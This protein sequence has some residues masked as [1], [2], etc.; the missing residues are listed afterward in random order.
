[1]N[2]KMFKSNHPKPYQRLVE[3]NTVPN[4]FHFTNMPKEHVSF[5]LHMLKVNS[6]SLP[7]TFLEG[8]ETAFQHEWKTLPP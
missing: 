3:I 5:Q 8:V 4:I 6:A 2:T 1:M 7:C